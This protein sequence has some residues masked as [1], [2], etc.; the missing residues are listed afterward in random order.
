[1]RGEDDFARNTRHGCAEADSF[2]LHARVD[3]FKHSEPAVTFIQ[4]QNGF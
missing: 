1:M 4:M 3:G 2:V